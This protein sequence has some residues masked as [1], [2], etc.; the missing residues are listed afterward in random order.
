MEK[1]YKKILKTGI[2]CENCKKTMGKFA[3]Y[4]T[5]CGSEMPIVLN[6]T[7]NIFENFSRF[8]SSQYVF[9]QFD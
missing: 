9:D 4:C 6:V 3:K 1:E 5:Y 2:K 8:L 7:P